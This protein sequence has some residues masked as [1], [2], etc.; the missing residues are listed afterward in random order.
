MTAEKTV[1]VN[2]S[3]TYRWDGKKYGP[4]QGVSV[5]AGMAQCLGLDPGSA[6]PAADP[7]APGPFNHSARSHAPTA[8]DAGRR[9]CYKRS[10]K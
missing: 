8:L 5:P 1:K 10:K 6:E 9:M 3:G 7:P 2:L 4:G